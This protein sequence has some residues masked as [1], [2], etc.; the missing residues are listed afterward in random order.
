[1]NLSFNTET[2]QRKEKKSKNTEI[3]RWGFEWEDRWS[4][5][6]RLFLNLIIENIYYDEAHV[7]PAHDCV[8]LSCYQLYIWRQ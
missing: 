6:N 1:M 8:I 5:A 2:R 3:D 4:D 7:H